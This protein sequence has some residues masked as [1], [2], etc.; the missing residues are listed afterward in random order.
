METRCFL[1]VTYMQDAVGDNYSLPDLN[2]LAHFSS[3]VNCY[4]R[5]RPYIQIGFFR[6]WLDANIWYIAM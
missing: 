4:P 2:Y 5:T 3:S 6:A 1:D